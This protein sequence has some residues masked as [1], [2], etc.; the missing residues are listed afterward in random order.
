MK[1]AIQRVDEL[2]PA[3]GGK[4]VA[5]IYWP[6]EQEGLLVYLK[7]IYSVLNSSVF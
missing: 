6:P 4:L 2:H 7:R 1:T 5:G 3:A